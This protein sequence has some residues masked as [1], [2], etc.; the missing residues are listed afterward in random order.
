MPVLKAL[1]APAPALLCLTS[2]CVY[3]LSFIALKRQRQEKISICLPSF[4]KLG[5]H[6]PIKDK[7][8]HCMLRQ[9]VNQAVAYFR[10]DTCAWMLTQACFLPTQF[11]VNEENVSV[12]SNVNA[13]GTCAHFLLCFS[14]SATLLTCIPCLH[15]GS[16]SRCPANSI[17]R[18]WFKP[19]RNIIDS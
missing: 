10:N 7:L 17:A 3:C 15:H 14:G 16:I 19:Y 8:S 18:K 4:C 5:P 6:E 13:R 12:S 2:E 11:C 1:Q 9:G